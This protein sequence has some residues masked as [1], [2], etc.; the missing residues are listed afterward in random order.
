MNKEKK[1]SLAI[2]L[3]VFLLTAFFLY[4]ALSLTINGD[5]TRFFPWDEMNDV[6]YV[7]KAEESVSSAKEWVEEESYYYSSVYKTNLNASVEAEIPEEEKDY[8]YTSTMYVLVS[9]PDLWQNRY[10]EL[11]ENAI[12]E[13]EKRRDSARPVSIF[14]WGTIS[15]EDEHLGVISVNPNEDGVWSEKD[16]LEM[17]DRVEKDPMVKYMLIGDSGN[18]VLLQF[19]YS[20]FGSSQQLES[21]SSVFQPL[22]DEGGRVVLM[23]NMVIAQ[24]VMKSL[25]KD[26]IVLLSLAL[27]IIFIVY[28]FSFH[29]TLYALVTASVS[30][31]AVIWTLGTMK[32]QGMDLNL[33]NILSPCMVATLGGTYAVHTISQYMNQIYNGNH[34]TGFTAVKRVL[35]TII[36]GSITTVAGFMCLS[37]SKE[38]GIGYFGAS[39]SFGVVFCALLS[40]TYLPS[41]LNLLPRPKE[42]S[43]DRLKNG[44]LQ[45]RIE[46]LGTFVV[47]HW[48]LLIIVFLALVGVFLLVKDGIGVNSDYM[49][50]FS[51][52]DPF[53]EDCRFFSREIGGTTPFSVTIEAPEGEDQFFLDMENLKMVKD[54]EDKLKESKHVL[55][56][57]SFPS[58]VAFANREITGEWDIP[59]DPGVGRIMKYILSMYMDELGQTGGIVSQDFNSITITIQAWD[60]NT[61]DLSSVESTKELY[62]E[63]VRSLDSLPPGS[64]VTISGYPIISMKFSDRMLK[65]QEA[66]TLWALAAVLLISSIVFLSPIKGVLVLIPVLSG[67]FFNIIFM[68]FMKIPY[69][70]ITISF[71]SIAVGAGVDDAIYFT[72]KYRMYRKIHHEKGVR[73]ALVETISLSGRPIILTTLSVVLGMSVLG[74]ASYTP[75]RY[76]GLLMAVTLL[77][78]MVSTLLFLPAFTILFSRIKRAVMKITRSKK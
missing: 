10:L 9:F 51:Q 34:T 67:I 31:I 77:G 16:A 62:N 44:W 45:R 29:S 54:W 72:L 5:F 55:Q 35:K 48:I 8:P 23:S 19:I 42:K 22:R 13:I 1:I 63:M 2:V 39:A 65:E 27:A 12:D 60:G 11:L 53:G 73:K 41:L 61:E 64:K 69:D 26:L 32:I 4:E 38:E 50:Y 24:E 37:L 68:Y 20:D 21:L 46:A 59:S 66:S 49:S 25:W 3:S 40:V 58:Y 6:Y 7:P 78:C 70:I 30:A 75:I 18:S 15:G 43:V 52:D 17:K 33:M 47:S 71:S 28:Y 74:F 56:V 76:F 57:I 14:D 36:I